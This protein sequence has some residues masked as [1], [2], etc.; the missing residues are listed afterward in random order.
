MTLDV[1]T[2]MRGRTEVIDEFGACTHTHTHK[3]HIY[4]IYTLYSVYNRY[5]YNIH[6]YT[7]TDAYTFYICLF[8]IL[9]K[10]NTCAFFLPVAFDLSAMSG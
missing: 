6:I 4:F 2:P 3:W 10:G 9:V 1:D 5:I 8:E 7:Y